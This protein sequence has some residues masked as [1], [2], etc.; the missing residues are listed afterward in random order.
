MSAIFKTKL[1]AVKTVKAPSTNGATS[2]QKKID[3]IL[4][5]DVEKATT[6]EF[7]KILSFNH[8][9]RGQ[10]QPIIDGFGGI[11]EWPE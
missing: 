11:A 9:D 10:R 7:S 6:R 1:A 5:A 2:E 8:V 4:I 3:A